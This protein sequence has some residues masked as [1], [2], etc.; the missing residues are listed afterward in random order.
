LTG[1]ILEVIALIHKS[2]VFGV[3]ARFVFANVV[4]R[5]VVGEFAVSQQVAQ[6]VR[7][8]ADVPVG[9]TTVALDLSGAGPHPTPVSG[10]DVVLAFRKW[11]L[12]TTAAFAYKK[13]VI[14]LVGL[15]Y[16]RG[17]EF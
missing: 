5:L 8:P 7:L 3:D 12:A 16:Y 9:E 1:H 6:A 4:Q 17:D 14:H 10:N 11:W 2:Q 13:E 15:H